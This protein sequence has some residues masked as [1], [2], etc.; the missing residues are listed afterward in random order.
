MVIILE[1]KAIL[2]QIS[3]FMRKYYCVASIVHINLPKPVRS[4]N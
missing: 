3:D 4:I 1:K 2:P